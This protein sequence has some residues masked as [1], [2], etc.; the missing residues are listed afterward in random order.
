MVLVDN[1]VLSFAMQLDNG[2]PILPFYTDHSDEEL[3]HLI[4]YLRCLVD[5]TDVRDHNKEAFA[6][7]K[8]AQME[9]EEVLM[10]NGTN[11]VPIDE[12]G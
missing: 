1:S 12:D 8:L 10:G 11:K 6:L 4:Y 9:L 2:I 7:N 3:L 5:E